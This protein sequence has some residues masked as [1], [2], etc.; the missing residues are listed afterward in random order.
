MYV[1]TP[2]EV[3]PVLK[4][5]F[6]SQVEVTDLPEGKQIREI[7]LED[8]RSLM[9]SVVEVP[10]PKPEEII[11]AMRKIACLR[12]LPTMSHALDCMAVAFDSRS[13][14]A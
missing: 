2:E 6:A 12:A 7:T 1:G 4:G 14:H 5:Q 3:Y 8:F 11:E 13:L 10:G 9:E